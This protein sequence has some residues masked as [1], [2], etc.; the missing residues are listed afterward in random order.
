MTGLT[1][2][3]HFD[4]KQWKAWWVEHRHLSDR[5]WLGA[6]A[7]GLAGRNDRLVTRF[8]LIEDRLV[9]V[10]RQL[11]RATP[12]EGRSAM[13]VSMLNDPLTPVRQLAI[14]LCIQRLTDTEPIGS[15]LRTALLARLDDQSS[16]NRQ[17]A[18]LL[19]RDL[20]DEVA[21]GAVAQ[22]L[23]SGTEKDPEV[24]RAYLLMMSKLPRQEVL[25]LAL[26]WLADPFLGG[27]A[28]GV[29]AT[30]VDAGLL[31]EQQGHEA[32]V[33]V[34]MLLDNSR[35]PK[36][37]F[38][39]LLGRVGSNKDWRR[40]AQ[41]IASDD[42]AIK[43][44][45]AQAWAD[46]PRPLK[47]LIQYAGDP[48][49]QPIVIAAARR[50]GKDPE[51][52][53]RLVEHKPQQEQV[54]QAWRLAVVAVAGRVSPVD[55]VLEIDR[56]LSQQEEPLEW[57]D[58]VLSAAIDQL[59]P[60]QRTNGSSSDEPGPE[61]VLDDAAKAV[62]IDLS[63]ARAQVRLANG[64]AA[65]ALVDYQRL[66]PVTGIMSTEQR[67]QHGLGLVET[68][69]VG[70]DVDAAIEWVDH[71]IA[72]QGDSTGDEVKTQIAEMFLATATRNAATEQM[73]VTRR[74]LAW[75]RSFVGQSG[76]LEIQSR[77]H[78]LEQRIDPDPKDDKAAS[79]PPA[80]EKTV[81]STRAEQ[82]PTI[83]Q[84]KPVPQK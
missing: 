13:L 10:Q 5:L 9:E 55:V 58:Q 6:V 81:G 14:D 56:Q 48:V 79:R 26:R 68:M 42:D 50:R 60:N 36:P 38:I 51:T 47:D 21:A 69:L 70:N 23:I 53:K 64:D 80:V 4:Q 31:G 66:E 75:L 29:L 18:A 71:W 82:S 12:Q 39:E 8:R 15:E 52:L 17:R 24:L 30:A 33:R 46:S 41:W 20:A 1:G 65:R 32:A 72:G 67:N 74:L 11:Y 16:T 7:D 62:W 83:P 37:K 22:R 63:F 54:V 40:I 73:D 59:V 76:S 34:R 3:D 78:E 35:E 44:T 28:A 43:Q 57:R 45:A 84:T 61:L 19:L 77:I 49:I 27:E 2:I 25:G